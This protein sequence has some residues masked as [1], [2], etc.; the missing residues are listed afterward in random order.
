LYGFIALRVKGTGTLLR[1]AHRA[2]VHTKETNTRVYFP[3]CR[4]NHA[5]GTMG[6]EKMEI[7]SNFTISVHT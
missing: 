5:G 7:N 2:K 4:Q 3:L 6:E 1:T